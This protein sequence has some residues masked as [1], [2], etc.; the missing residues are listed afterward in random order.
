M[1]FEL[2][3]GNLSFR[4]APQEHTDTVESLIAKLNAFASGFQN[5]FD[6]SGHVSPV[7][8]YQNLVQFTIELDERDCVKSFSNAVPVL[9]NYLPEEVITFTL[10]ELIHENSKERWNQI[11][12]ELKAEDSYETATQLLFRTKYNKVLPCFC[13]VAKHHYSTH[14]VISSV[15][16]ILQDVL[17]DGNNIQS[18][19]P[20]K[21]DA[22]IIQNI[23]E[24]I[25]EHLEEPMPST[26]QLA[27][28]FGTNELKIKRGFRQ[29]YNTS[30]YQYYNDERLKKGHYLIQKTDFPLKEIAFMSGFNDYPTFSKAFKKK[31]SYSPSDVKRETD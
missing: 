12:D 11:K 8:H 17:A 20:R 14:M 29:H 15:T 3:T 9:L 28:L 31:Y 22:A 7:Y 6:Q 23:C 16:T 19:K 30:L 2:A 18:I 24:Y 25:K 1:L 13:S 26:R 27:L 5:A 4:L 21:S 10:S